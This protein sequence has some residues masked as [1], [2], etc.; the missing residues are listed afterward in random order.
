MEEIKKRAAKLIDVKSIMTLLLTL[1][2]CVMALC[3]VI[4][5]EQFLTIFVTIVGFYFG[6]QATK[7]TDG[8]EA[9]AATQ[10]PASVPETTVQSVTKTVDQ[11]MQND[12]HPPDVVVEGF[13]AAV[14][15]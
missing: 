14:S 11:A 1:V 8:T 3:G 2:F 6:T 4:S 15:E 10:Q 9:K 5:G 13:G 7:K 12:V